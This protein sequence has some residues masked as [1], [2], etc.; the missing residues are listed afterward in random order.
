MSNFTKL[1]VAV[2][3]VVVVGSGAS[4][5][6]YKGQTETL[7]AQAA[8]DVLAHAF[9]VEP[10][11]ES[12]SFDPFTGEMR[13]GG[14]RLA[15]PPGFDD[16]PMLEIDTAVAQVDMESL[17][18]ARAQVR[19]LALTGVHVRLLENESSLVNLQVAEDYI[20]LQKEQRVA[21]SNPARRF[22]FAEYTLTGVSFE[23]VTAR[24]ERYGLL[25][26]DQQ[27]TK[28]GY[29][30]G[31]L[32]VYETLLGLL[33]PVF[34]GVVQRAADE[35]LLPSGRAEEQTLRDLKRM[36]DAINAPPSTED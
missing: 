10:V 5:V 13:A 6:Y 22:A 17:A 24:G 28:L 9:G 31:G 16:G 8:H 36:I 21:D 12:F 33:Q 23:A 4:I 19:L 20:A 7:V 1:M 25:L 11:I 32:P 3:A 15:N 27:Y 29:D 26:D 18:T 34:S 14:I 35:G 2:I 30:S